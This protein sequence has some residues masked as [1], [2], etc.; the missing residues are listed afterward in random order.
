[1]LK[2]SPCDLHDFYLLAFVI[3]TF[4]G[5]TDCGSFLFAGEIALLC[6]P[7]RKQEGECWGRICR[8]VSKAAAQSSS[9]F[10]IGLVHLRLGSHVIGCN[11][12]IQQPSATSLKQSV[13]DRLGPLITASSEPSQDPSTDPQVC[14]R[15]CDF[16]W[17]SFTLLCLYLHERPH[18]SSKNQYWITTWWQVSAQVSKQHGPALCWFMIGHCLHA[19]AH[20][21]LVCGFVC[22]YICTPTQS[23]LFFSV[24][25][26]IL[27][28]CL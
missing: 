12:V 9:G 6:A 4:Q 24:P 18:L 23:F 15:V 14:V 27:Q 16:M 11:C 3:Y 2:L 7:C 19:T 10:D 13:K 20:S 22:M 26:S 25:G 8:C 28:K 5:K 17:C 1:M 21:A